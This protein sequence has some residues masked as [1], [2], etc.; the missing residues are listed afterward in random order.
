MIPLAHFGCTMMTT[1]KMEELENY[2]ETVI[3]ANRRGS[4]K[5]PCPREA[6][7][8][9]AFF[10]LRD[11]DDAAERHA[12]A[13]ENDE[14]NNDLPFDMFWIVSNYKHSPFCLLVSMNGDQMETRSYT[15][16]GSYG[17]SAG[18][19]AER[20]AA[21]EGMIFELITAVSVNERDEFE[22]AAQARINRGRAK[23]IGKASYIPAMPAFIHITSEPR[24]A[25][26]PKGGT[27]ASPIPHDRRGHWRQY[28]ATGKRVWVN[29]SK[30]NGGSPVGRNYVIA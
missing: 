24:A 29:N 3:E 16:Y 28:K 22:S 7:F 25:S 2:F 23:T 20:R 6:L 30:I 10:Y 18:Q 15:G 1:P 26:S 27:H 14:G 11:D 8:A 4:T 19:R 9:H 12:K 21:I 17:L 5:V 13:A